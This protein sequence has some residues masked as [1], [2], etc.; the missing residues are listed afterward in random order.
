VDIKQLNAFQA[1]IPD[2]RGF[3]SAQKEQL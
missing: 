1:P 3:Q 2:L